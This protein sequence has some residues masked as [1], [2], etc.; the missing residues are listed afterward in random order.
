MSTGSCS[1]IKG[2]MFSIV[3]IFLF[4]SIVASSHAQSQDPKDRRQE[5]A[6]EYYKKWLTEDVTY[7]ISDEERAVFEKL[8][9]SDERDQFIEQFWHRRN[10]DFRV[11]TNA[12]K[13]EHYRRIAYANENYA[14][15]MDGW[16]ADRGRIYIMYGPP[17]EVERYP[18][19]GNYQ[20][21]DHEG[22]GF[23]NVYPFERWW[24]RHLPGVGSDVEL[25]FVDPRMS[26]EYYLAVNAE[27]K[28]ALLFVPGAGPTLAEDLGMANKMDRPYFVSNYGESYPGMN[29]RSKDDPMRRY[30][31]Y[32]K[33]HNPP[34]IK[35]KDL[36]EM[37]EIN[38]TFR[39]LPFELR[40]DYFRLNETQVLAPVTVQ[41]K[42]RDLTLKESNGLHHINVVVYG[43]VT[44]LT[45]HV[46]FEFEDEVV[47]SY[48][49]EEL[50]QGLSERSMYQ[51]IIPIDTKMRYKLDLVVKDLNS[52][53]V[54]TVRKAL[55][56]PSYSQDKLQSSSLVLSG[57]IQHLAEAAE[58]DRM[59]V[60]GDIWIRPSVDHVFYSYDP[61]GVYWQ[62]Y[63]AKVDQAT[64]APALRTSYRIRKDGTV[65]RE[66][67]DN[68]GQ[69]TQFFS[70]QRLV[71]IKGLSLEGLDPGDYNLEVQVEDLI[72]QQ[73][74]ISSSDFT[75][76]KSNL[77]AAR[78]G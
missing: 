29:S 72:G 67:V 35:Y 71:L 45:N 76:G 61:L 24:Y 56:P 6:Q 55:I 63:N 77:E 40:Q 10:P 68:G 32:F 65:V 57:F 31:T 27:E 17:D 4:C 33:V 49:K 11:K 15:G 43:V 37:V 39:D 23:T 54:G 28:D 46:S 59:F 73:E 20:R 34:P 50:N 52:A 60:L 18:T 69:S 53:R 21:Q 47:G 13:E 14:S 78:G 70:G 1:A 38:I 42:N 30:E 9:T 12:F 7:I 58:R 44:T 16:K 62:I 74:V 2:G 41:F 51:K 3:A 66:A 19:G 8:T 26:N 75:I 22:G 36:K 48:T 25:E 64:S 5:E